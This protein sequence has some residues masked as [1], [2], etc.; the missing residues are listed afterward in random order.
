MKHIFIKTKHIPPSAN[1]CFSNVKGKGRVRTKRYNTWI[2]AAGWDFNGKGKVSGRF[3]C[4]ITID[5]SKRRSNADIDNRIK[6][7]LDLLQKH[8]LIEDDK[9]CESVTCKWGEADGGMSVL[10]EPYHL[11][12]R[13]S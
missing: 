8:G 6:P 5:R 10:I 7:T 12:V 11:N 1:A 13:A 4:V 2:A 9:L 3:A